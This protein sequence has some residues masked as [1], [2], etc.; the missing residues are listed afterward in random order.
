MYVCIYELTSPNPSKYLSAFCAA[1]PAT[2]ESV[3][4]RDAAQMPGCAKSSIGHTHTP[5]E[6]NTPDTDTH[7]HR[8]ITTPQTPKRT[9]P[10]NE[11][12]PQTLNNARRWRDDGACHLPR[13]GWWPRRSANRHGNIQSVSPRQLQSL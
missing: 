8:A 10:T 6:N 9:P 4:G 12:L 3:V 13:P 7:T 11:H 5:T 2:I 1:S